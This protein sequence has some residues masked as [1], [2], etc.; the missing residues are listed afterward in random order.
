MNVPFS[1]FISVKHGAEKMM[2]KWG[3]S[4]CITAYIY[5]LKKSYIHVLIYVYAPQAGLFIP[6]DAF[7]WCHFNKLRLCSCMDFVLHLFKLIIT[8]WWH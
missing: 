3:T 1:L 5:K 2:S 4:K 8:Y 7:L 6:S